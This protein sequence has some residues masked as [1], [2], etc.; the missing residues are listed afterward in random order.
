M[1]SRV[2]YVDEAMLY[3]MGNCRLLINSKGIP[4]PVILTVSLEIGGIIN[5]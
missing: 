3:Y 2:G 5:N 4:H 1:K